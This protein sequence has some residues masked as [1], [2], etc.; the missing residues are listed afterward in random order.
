MIRLPD[1]EPSPRPFRLALR[2]DDAAEA[3]G[4]SRRKLQ[5]LTQPNGPIPFLRVGTA[6]L[7][8]VVDL[9]RF[10]ADGRDEAEAAGWPRQKV[11]PGNGESGLANAQATE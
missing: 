6:V 8:R 7:Y 9:D 2:P 1:P 11:N 4:I 10:L 5:D 3:L